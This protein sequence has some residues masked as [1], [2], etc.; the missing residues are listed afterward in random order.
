[1]TPI[2]L[3]A[4]RRSGLLR[5]QRGRHGAKLLAGA[6]MSSSDSVTVTSS[7][8]SFTNRGVT[9]PE[10]EHAQIDAVRRMDDIHPTC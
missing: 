6:A 9:S 4:G 10:I 1:M 5:D 3:R 8:G 7:R 2:A